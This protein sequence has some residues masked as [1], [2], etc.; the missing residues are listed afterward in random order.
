MNNYAE[1]INSIEDLKNIPLTMF[2]TDDGM[3]YGAY[4]LR[5]MDLGSAELK[6]ADLKYANLEGANLEDTNLENANLLGANLQGANLQGANL[7]GALMDMETEEEDNNQ[8]FQGIAYEIHNKADKLILNEKFLTTIGFYKSPRLNTF[9][10]EHILPLFIN[11][12]NEE[13]NFKN[14]N[15]LLLISN[16]VAV[17]N[18]ARSCDIPT[19]DKANLLNQAINFAFEQDSRFTEAYIEIYIDETFNAYSSS[20]DNI[21]CVAGIIERFYTSLLSAALQVDTIEGFVKTDELQT[22]YCIAKTGNLQKDPN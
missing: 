4:D 17:Y 10:Y 22:L 6:G 18:K 20:T 7:Q 1:S 14:S 12:I 3:S 19:G 11:F 2:T 15:K 13:D 21:S 5:D 16:L 9:N 8:E